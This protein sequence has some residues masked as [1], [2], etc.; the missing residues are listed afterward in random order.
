MMCCNTCIIGLKNQRFFTHPVL[1]NSIEIKILY[2]QWLQGHL[3]VTVKTLVKALS[4]AIYNFYMQ[5]TVKTLVK[6]LSEAI[7]IISIRIY[8]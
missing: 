2:S 8:T 1:M 4:E 5:V 6:A 3:Q 7:Y